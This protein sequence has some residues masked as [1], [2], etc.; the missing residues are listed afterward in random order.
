PIPLPPCLPLL[1]YTTLFR[2]CTQMG[3]NFCKITCPIGVVGVLLSSPVSHHI[4]VY[5]FYNRCYPKGCNS[6]ILQ[7]RNLI[8][9]ASKI[10][11]VVDRKSTRLNSSHV[12]ISY[13]V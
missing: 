7:I 9:Y 6:K 5:V 12:S 2:S 3:I 4:C 8:D 13:A 11:T 1:P 10:A